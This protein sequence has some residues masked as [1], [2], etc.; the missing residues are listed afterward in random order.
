MLG[1]ARAEP[2]RTFLRSFAESVFDGSQPGARGPRH[3]PNRFCGSHW[4]RE[5]DVIVIEDLSR[6]SRAAADLF[7]VQRLFEFLEVR[8]I[9][10][11]DVRQAF[12]A[13][14]RAE[15]PGVDDLHQRSQGQDAARLGGARS[16]G[17]RGPCGGLYCSVASIDTVR[18]AACVPGRLSRTGTIECADRPFHDRDGAC[19]SSARDRENSSSAIQSV[20]S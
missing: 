14:V 9:G 17:G 13:Y 18:P 8:L 2:A 16:R 11:V 10:I 20:K 6:L 19:S 4:R 5:I 3:G 1:R 15:E 12:N 7:T